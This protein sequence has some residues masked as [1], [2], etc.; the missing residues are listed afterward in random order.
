MSSTSKVAGAIGA[1]AVAGA[2]AYYVTQVRGCPPDPGPPDAGVSAD[3]A[4]AEPDAGAVIVEE[5]ALKWQWNCNPDPDAGPTAPRGPG[6]GGDSG[7]SVNGFAPSCLLIQDKPWSEAWWELAHGPLNL[8]KEDGMNSLDLCTLDE[9]GKKLMHYLVTC[10]LRPD[11]SIDKPCGGDPV[12]FRGRLGVAPDWIDNA[13]T[14]RTGAP[15]RVTACL[16]AHSNHDGQPVDIAPRAP[17]LSPPYTGPLPPSSHVREGAFAGNLFPDPPPPGGQAPPQD[18][19]LYAF[20]HQDFTASS[21]SA[22]NGRI[23]AL[24]GAGPLNACG[25]KVTPAGDCDSPPGT[26]SPAAYAECKTGDSNTD[27]DANPMTVYSAK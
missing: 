19:G 22:G 15:E 3:A 26:Q 9:D 1:V 27:I 11:Q 5:A 12:E 21:Q 18:L 24:P 2:A 6:D 23:C 8:L 16:M 10:A 14:S 20:H 13:L 25:F 7:M 4:T 17:Y